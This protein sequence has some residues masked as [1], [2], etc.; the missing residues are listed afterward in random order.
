[1]TNGLTG[2][3]CRARSVKCEKA[4]HNRFSLCGQ[5]KQMR[6][7]SNM[8]KDAKDVFVCDRERERV[9]GIFIENA[10]ISL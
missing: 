9:G 2:D 3:Y 8:E 10:L 4:C 5:H 1:M 6:D 7:A